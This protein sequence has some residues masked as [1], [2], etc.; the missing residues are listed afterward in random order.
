MNKLAVGILA[1]GSMLTLGACADMTPYQ[2][3]TTATGAGIGAVAGA[4]VSDRPLEGAVVGGALGAAAGSLYGQSRQQPSR[5][6]YD[7]SGRAY[8][9][10]QYGRPYYLR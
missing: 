8:S 2:Q 9:I 3:N 4:L 1:G 10:D 5:V 6:Y 7:Q